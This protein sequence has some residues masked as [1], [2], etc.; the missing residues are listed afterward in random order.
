MIVVAI[1]GILAALA[2][3]RFMAASTKS[4]Q[5][6]AKQLLKQIYMMEQVYRQENDAYWGNGIS[7]TRNDQDAFSRIGVQIPASAR[8]I[9]SIV[10]GA[11]TFTCTAN[12]PSPGLDDDATPDTWTINEAGTLVCTSDDSEN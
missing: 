6:E 3:P 8:Y 1:I 11:N 12:V 7:A 5:S 2:I 9:Y 10:A 4:K